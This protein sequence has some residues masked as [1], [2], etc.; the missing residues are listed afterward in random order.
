MPGAG[1]VEGTGQA[2]GAAPRGGALRPGGCW[3]TLF[4]GPGAW[5]LLGVVV[6]NTVPGMGGTKMLGT[7]PVKGSWTRRRGEAA[8]KCSP[9]IILCVSL[10]FSNKGET[11]RENFSR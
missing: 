10:F 11:L 9:R 5:R 7:T 4:Q 1:R 6:L 8:G 3:E 2:W